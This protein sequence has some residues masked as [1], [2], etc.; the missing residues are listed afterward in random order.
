MMRLRSILRLRPVR[1]GAGFCSR[2]GFTTWT[3]DLL[4]NIKE[5]LLTSRLGTELFCSQFDTAMAGTR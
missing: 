2:D 1:R 4:S 3:Q 5:R